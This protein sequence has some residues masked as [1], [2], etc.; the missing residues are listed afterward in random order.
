[1]RQVTGLKDVEAFMVVS[2][3]FAD[4]RGTKT[5]AKVKRI[6]RLEKLSYGDGG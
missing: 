5:K 1:M 4:I 2:I 3:L 6:I